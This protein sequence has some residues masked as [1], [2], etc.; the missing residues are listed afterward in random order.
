[1]DQRME[2]RQIALIAIFGAPA[3][4][5]NPTFSGISV[6]APFFPVLLYEVWEIPIVVVLFLVGP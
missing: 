6:P 4:A 5:L 1:M 2:T 3:I